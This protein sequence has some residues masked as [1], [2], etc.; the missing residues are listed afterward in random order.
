MIPFVHQFA[1]IVF[2]TDQVTFSHSALRRAISLS[3][4]S[5]S[6]FRILLS[7]SKAIA[8]FSAL[9]RESSLA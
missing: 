4:S 3:A 6:F 8:L 9:E 2:S 1:V 5:F 7:S